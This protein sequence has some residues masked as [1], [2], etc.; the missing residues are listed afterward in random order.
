MRMNS[1]TRRDIAVMA[2]GLPI[3]LSLVAIMVLSSE[4]DMK[5]A[6]LGALGPLGMA[7]MNWFTRGRVE[8]PKDE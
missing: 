5:V 6:A 2:L 7:A 1:D 4:R 3:I 8:R